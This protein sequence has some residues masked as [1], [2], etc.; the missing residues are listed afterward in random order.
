MLWSCDPVRRVRSLLHE[1]RDHALGSELQVVA[2][3]S[4]TAAASSAAPP[5]RGFRRLDRPDRHRHPDVPE[6]GL[7]GYEFGEDFQAAVAV[8]PGSIRPLPGLDA[9]IGL[10]ESASSLRRRVGLWPSLP[11]EP[12]A[13]SDGGRIHRASCDSATVVEA[14]VYGVL[15][16]CAGQGFAL[17]V[18]GP[19]SPPMVDC[20][21]V[22][23]K[24]VPPR[25]CAAAGAPS[26]LLRRGVR[27]GR[28]EEGAWRCC[29]AGLGG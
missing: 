2:S 13:D 14:G 5:L 4:I 15:L 16:S 19:S 9:L 18:R 25:R 17:V 26:G 21:L 6:L 3:R 24:V 29:R 11:T 22:G 27:A 10:R 23:V 7:A 8:G 1:V 20:R 28:Y 12:S